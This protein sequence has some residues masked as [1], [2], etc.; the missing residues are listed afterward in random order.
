MKLLLAEDER[1]LSNAIVRILKHNNFIVDAAYDGVEALEYLSMEEYDGV[2]LDIMMPRLDGISVVKKLREQGNNIPVLLLTAKAE[3]DDRVLGL[4]SGA[5][6][7]LTKPF[8]M[9]ELIARIRAM[10]RRKS[11]VITT[12]SFGNMKLNPQTFEMQTDKGVTRLTSKEYQMLELLVSHPKMLISTEKFMENVWGYDTEAEINVVW[13]Y[14]SALR[15]KL[16]S[17]GANVII[18]AVR[19]VGYKLEE[20]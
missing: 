6:D 13:V 4:D 5:D 12:F 14:I 10:T 2:I 3:I 7:Y 9:K 1:E 15:K 8:A 18:K 16:T 20:N 11:D 17:I 19:G